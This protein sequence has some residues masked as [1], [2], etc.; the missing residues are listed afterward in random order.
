MGPSWFE[1]RKQSET[2]NELRKVSPDDSTKSH[3]PP[4][5]HLYE[6]SFTAEKTKLQK[7]TWWPQGYQHINRWRSHTSSSWNT[8]KWFTSLIH[9]WFTSPT[10]IMRMFSSWEKG[11]LWLL[12]TAR[13]S[14]LRVCLEFRRHL[15]ITCQVNKQHLIQGTVLER[16]SQWEQ[17]SQL[18]ASNFFH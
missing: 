15:I 12:L 16:P 18:Y 3:S 2:R 13:A 5:N 17:Y 10:P 8:L 1:T 11:F 6:L 7:C 4:R 9:L 14:A